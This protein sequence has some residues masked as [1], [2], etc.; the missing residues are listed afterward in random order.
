MEVSVF[1][2]EVT[3]WR[4]SRLR[5][6]IEEAMKR[7][8]IYIRDREATEYDDGEYTVSDLMGD[9]RREFTPE[10]EYGIHCKKL[11][12]YGIYSFFIADDGKTFYSYKRTDEAFA[13]DH[14]LSR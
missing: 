1:A 8:Y 9:P 12:E 6:E 10:A 14:A 3:R 11:N 4:D 2:R 13:K 5:S 7:F